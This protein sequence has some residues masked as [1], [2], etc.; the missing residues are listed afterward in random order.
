[1]IAVSFKCR[2]QILRRLAKGNVL[3]FLLNWGLRC[4]LPETQP[5]FFTFK[6]DCPSNVLSGNKELLIQEGV[7]ALSINIPTCPR[8]WF[9]QEDN[10]GGFFIFFFFFGFFFL[11]ARRRIFFP[12]EVLKLL[13]A[14]VVLYLCYLLR[15]IPPGSVQLSLTGNN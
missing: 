1:M 11:I 12:S 5:D 13:W 14:V 3:S 4:V 8:L 7:G 15:G 10:P 6:Y 9:C 2:C